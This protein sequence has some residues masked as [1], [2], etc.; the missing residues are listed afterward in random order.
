MYKRTN[1][2]SAVYKGFT[3]DIFLISNYVKFYIQNIKL[4][5]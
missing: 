3:D 4:E 2:Y 5:N 1:T